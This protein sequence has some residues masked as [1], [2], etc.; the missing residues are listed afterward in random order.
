MAHHLIRAV[1]DMLVV[2]RTHL[3]LAPRKFAALSTPALLSPVPSRNDG[4]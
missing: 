3:F 4:L 2:L 1:H